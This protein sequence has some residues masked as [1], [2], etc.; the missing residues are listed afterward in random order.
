MFGNYLHVNS[1][2]VIRSLHLRLI[3]NTEYNLKTYDHHDYECID[4]CAQLNTR[5]F[6]FWSEYEIR[7][8]K[9]N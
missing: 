4:E 5:S 8:L 2:P 1:H 7:R 3:K 9:E 6:F